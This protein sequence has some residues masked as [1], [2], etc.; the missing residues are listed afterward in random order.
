MRIE[1]PHRHERFGAVRIHELTQV[2]ELDSGL[3]AVEQES[4]LE[5]RRVRR[6]PPADLNDVER[7]MAVVIPTRNERRKVIDGVLS[8]VPHDCPIFLVSASDRRPVDR[9]DLETD[10][11]DELVRVTGRQAFAIHQG[12]PGVGRAVVDAGLGPLVG[13][14]ATVRPGKGEAMVVALL[15]VALSGLDHVAFVDADNYVPGAVHEYIKCF[16]AGLHLASGP[17]GMV[18]ISWRSKPKVEGARLV[19]NRWGRTSEITNRFL[20]LVLA[21]Y[22]GFGTDVIAT[23]NAGEHAMTMELARRLR[24]AGGYA[25]EAYEI[26]DLFEQFG[27]ALPSPHPEVIGRLVDVFQ[28]ETRNPHLHEDRGDDHIAGMRTRSLN[29]L[30]HS[31][32]CPDSTRA[33]ITAFLEAEGLVAPGATPEPE[34]VYGPIAGADLA[35]FGRSLAAAESYRSW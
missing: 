14:T 1:L 23:G 2:V 26:V 8:G 35:A 29:A 30:F 25:V 33:E 27:G 28:I 34:P 17:Y 3:G 24:Y 18:R 11:L 31:P 20:N 32:V 19:F 13:P 22:T 7:R 16:A 9:Y 21:T 4:Q 5:G 12:D 10:L 15:M 6:I